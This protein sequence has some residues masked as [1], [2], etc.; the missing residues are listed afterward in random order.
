MAAITRSMAQRADRLA[1]PAFASA[2][3]WCRNFHIVGDG[4]FRQT[5]SVEV[6]DE[7]TSIEPARA[8]H[9]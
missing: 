9:R 4:E 2:E 3:G 1:A 5:V 7:K 8:R 6:H